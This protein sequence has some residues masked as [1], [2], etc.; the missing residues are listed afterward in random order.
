MADFINK[1]IRDPNFLLAKSDQLLNDLAEI[2]IISRQEAQSAS[3]SQKQL[4]TK[5]FFETEI[6]CISQKSCNHN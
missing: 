2:G 5:L 3:N 6:N 4:V 1:N